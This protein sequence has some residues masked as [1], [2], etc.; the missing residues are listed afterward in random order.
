MAGY[1]IET[2]TAEDVRTAVAWA[3]REG[4]NPGL[5]DA[6]TFFAA[7]QSGFFK[8]VLD[9]EIIAT[10]SAV[11]YDDTYAFCGLYIVAP[12]HRGKGFGLALTKAR[13]AYCGDRNVGIDGVLENVRIYERIGYVP[14]YENCRYEGEAAAGAF[15]SAAVSDIKT[16]D[17]DAIRTYDRQCFPAHR[18]AFLKAWLGQGGARAVCYRQDGVVKGYAVRRKCLEG[19][20]VGPLFADNTEVA[21][22]L[23]TA[24]QAD[25][26]GEK[27]ILD[28]P[29]NN[30][31]AIRLATKRGMQKV[32]A[33]ARM[34]QKG[35]PDIRT[36]QIFGITTF[37]LG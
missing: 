29:E 32:F 23:F 30:P 33:T 11:V 1:T 37:E 5:H 24:L 3:G 17:F 9:G 22:T 27:I 16:A 13:L 21:E 34:Y 4:W 15:D 28:T 12:E 10:G 2:M 26:P 14:Y 36:G 20:K 35:L 8:G 7:D 31:E 6:E 18:D 25:I 19:H